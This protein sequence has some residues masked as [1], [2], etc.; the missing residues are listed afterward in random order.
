MSEPQLHTVIFERNTKHINHWR[1]ACS[2]GWYKTGQEAEVKALAAIHDLEWEK[3]ETFALPARTPKV[4][5]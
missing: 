4:P 5:R 1:A 3:V 2:C